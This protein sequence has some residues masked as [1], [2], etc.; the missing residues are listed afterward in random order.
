MLHG[1]INPNNIFIIIDR[2]TP[3]E[4][5]PDIMKLNYRNSR[6]YQLGDWGISMPLKNFDAKSF[7]LKKLRVPITKW[8]SLTGGH[9]GVTAL[10]DPHGNSRNIHGQPSMAFN[11]MAC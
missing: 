1:D 6:K 3:D 10:K 4:A 11:R 7:N 8:D 9:S 5:I 2:A